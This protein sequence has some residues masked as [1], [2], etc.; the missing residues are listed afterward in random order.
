MYAANRMHHHAFVS[1]DLERTRFFYEETIGLPLSLTWCEG[2]GTEAYCHVYFELEDGSCLAFFQF[3]DKEAAR[4]HSAAKAQSPFYHIALNSS[5]IQQSAV[6]TRART[7]GL[8]PH[9]I[10]HGYC[11]SLYLTDPDGLIVELTVDNHHSD[12]L[13]AQRKQAPH[14][15]LAK[16][17]AGDHG[18]N[19]TLRHETVAP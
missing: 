9:L 13:I 12:A 2:E 5:T 19:N 11:T 3:A 10:D 17:L 18:S 8:E 7:N 16:W 6:E 15:E 4:V 1:L 14:A